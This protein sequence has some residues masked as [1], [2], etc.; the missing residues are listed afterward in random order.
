MT[1]K[2]SL[3]SLVCPKLSLSPSN[4]R[5]FTVFTVRQKYLRKSKRQ[6]WALNPL[7]LLLKSKKTRQVIPKT[8]K[9]TKMKTW[10]LKKAK[11]TSRKRLLKS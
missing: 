8:P 4:I 11:K 10:K 2:W 5:H 7:E 9:P 1:R 6:K 3:T